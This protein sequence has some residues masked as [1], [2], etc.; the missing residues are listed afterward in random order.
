MKRQAVTL[1]RADTGTM[2]PIFR[3]VLDELRQR[4]VRWA[5]LRSP[6][7]LMTPLDGDID[8]LVHSADMSAARN[9]FL[10]LGFVR[11][12]RVGTHFLAFDAPTD[13]W[14]W[15]HVV[16]DLSFLGGQVKTYAAEG[17]LARR[18]DSE[19][20]RLAPDDG[21]WVLL[22]HCALD[23]RAVAA[24]HRSTLQRDAAKELLTGPMAAFMA[25]FCGTGSAAV[26]PHALVEMIIREQWTELERTLWELA[27]R[28]MHRHRASFLR[29]RWDDAAQ[30]ADAAKRAIRSPGLSV[31]LL[32]PDGA[33]KS[34]LAAGIAQSFKMPVSIMYMGLTGGFLKQVDRL[35]VPGVVFVGRAM[36]IWRRY[37]RGRLHQARGRLVVFD[38]YVLDAAV[39]HPQ[40]LNRMQ[41]MS[42]WL[43]FYLCPPPDLVL[44]LDAP[45][46]VMHRRKG[47]YQADMLEDW[48]RHF[49]DLQRRFPDAVEIVDA[50]Q[51]KDAVRIDATQ[52]ILR[53]YRER[54]VD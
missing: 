38:R 24:R 26:T 4:Q 7:D 5:L 40:R 50:S 20:P 16:D 17:C 33:G 46:D 44:V 32:G 12:P 25:R 18:L 2:H 8:V 54:D 10:A 9:I 1:S 39:P 30:Y 14:F 29:R 42:R 31:A 52:R 41:R 19:L 51:D 6:A 36:V 22:L 37:L 3:A 53:R 43:D 11:V 23:K 27:D 35:R 45:G 49:R 15:F 28:W 48:R 47:E 21:F 34:T 13:Q